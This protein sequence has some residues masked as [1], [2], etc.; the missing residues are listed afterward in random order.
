MYSLD[1]IN[2]FSVALFANIFS[3]L[4]LLTVYFAVQKLINLIKSPKTLLQYMS[5]NVF[6]MFSSKSFMV[7][8]L[9]FKFLRHFEF[10]FVYGVREYSKFINLHAAVQLSQ[11]HLLKRLSFLNCVFLPPSSNIN[12]CV[13]LLWALCGVVPYIS[14]FC[15]ST[16]LF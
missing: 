1:A 16:T 7:S 12:C 15:A 6:P 2:P 3:L 5:E 10:I 11:Y 4:I 9:I 8:C 14:F 13:D